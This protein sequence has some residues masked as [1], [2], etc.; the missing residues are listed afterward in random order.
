MIKRR[1]GSIPQ[2]SFYVDEHG[3]LWVASGVCPDGDY[4]VRD[5]NISAGRNKDIS[6]DNE[7]VTCKLVIPNREQGRKYFNEPRITEETPR[8][9]AHQVT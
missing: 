7:V 1:V 4:P 8:E 6:K 3:D 5:F 9:E 2:G